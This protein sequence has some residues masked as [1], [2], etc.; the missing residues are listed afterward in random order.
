VDVGALYKAVCRAGRYVSGKHEFA[1]DFFEYLTTTMDNQELSTAKKHCVCKGPHLTNE[2]MILCNSCGVWFHKCCVGDP[3]GQDKWVYPTCQHVAL[4][5]SPPP[6]GILAGSVFEC[7]QFLTG[8]FYEC[9]G[10]SAHGGSAR[11]QPVVPATALHLKL[12]KDVTGD[13][14]RYSLT[15]LVRLALGSEVVSE[16]ERL[17]CRDCAA[18]GGD[19]RDC[20][21]DRAQHSV[22][23][24]QPPLLALTLARKA[25]AGGAKRTDVAEFKTSDFIVPSAPAWAEAYRLKVPTSR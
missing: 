6:I 14:L 24:S 2:E 10:C 21:Q 9:G 19:R 7:F 25:H 23:G 13:Q 12:P 8:S 11:A 17:N 3:S 22:V 1:L 18:R 15:E 5:Q 16:E 4:P 20:P